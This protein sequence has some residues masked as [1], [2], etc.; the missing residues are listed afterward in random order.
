[1]KVINLLFFSI[2]IYLPATA[3]IEKIRA[4]QD[5]LPYI[6]DS[7]QYI[8]QLN[9]ISLL[10]YEQ[11]ADSTLF[12]ALH[13]REVAYRQH[14]PK[15]LADATNNL[16]IVYDIKGN[17]QLALR[18]YNDAYNQYTAQKDSSNIVQTLMNIAAVYNISGKDQKAITNY[19]RALLLGNQIS[20]DSITAIV[21]YNYMLSYPAKFTAEK[22]AELIEN[23]DKI[24]EK[25]HDIR[26]KLAIQQ[27]KA[28]NLIS[29]KNQKKGIEMLEK[30][31]DQTLELQLFYLSMDILMDLGDLY[32][33]SDSTKGIS[34]YKQALKIAEMKNYRMYAKEVSNKLYKIYLDKHDNQTAF[35]Y[36][37]KLLRLF[38]RQIEIDRVSGIDYIE[39]A[40]KDQELISAHLKAD[41]NARKLWLAIAV[42]ILTLLS[43]IFLWRN[44]K[45]SAKTN[46]ILTLQFQQ[47]EST[48]Q[49]L[50]LSNNNYAKL[51]KVVAHDLRNPISAVSSLTTLLQ[52]ETL[53]ADERREFVSLIQ[54][55]SNSS[56]HLISDLLQT[57][58]SFNESELQKEK[59]DLPA[60]LRQ[61]LTLLRFRANDKNQKLNLEESGSVTIIA[62]RDKLLRV[63]NNL[64]INAIKFSPEGETIRIGTQKSKEG[65]TIFVEDHGLGI[66]KNY[67]EKLF[68]PFTASK[69]Q[70]TA[71]EQ[72]FGLGLYISKQIVEAHRGK[73]WFESEEGNGSVFYIFLPVESSGNS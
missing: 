1:M 28:N 55:S 4:L 5:R 36:S 6:K 19:D 27:L 72:P 40:V 9:K 29:N 41:Y 25:Y 67:A 31:L 3:Q 16:G 65:I 64:I 18:Y 46:S 63:L 20:H 44:W 7:I 68:D 61:A 30:T 73:I 66:P 38:E 22:K 53:T 23:A 21:V 69:R 51:I 15:G 48:S 37:Q 12:Y 56:L 35:I 60:F 39:Y 50:E 47:L 62:D 52:D 11:N 59:I 70:G 2:L 8:N 49:A 17:I 33:K 43:L 57:D 26:L 13:A 14:Y 34:F 32:I 71:G 24:S 45:L 10:F 58:F 54:E 42:C